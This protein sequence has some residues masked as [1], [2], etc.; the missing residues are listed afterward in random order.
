MD[1]FCLVPP[2]S[3]AATSIDL[4]VV[5]RRLKSAPVRRSND[6]ECLTIPQPRFDLPSGRTRRASAKATRTSPT[7]ERTEIVIRREV[8]SAQGIR[9]R[10]P[11]KFSEQEMQQLLERVYGDAAAVVVDPTPPTVVVYAHDVAA[12]KA[13]PPVQV[14]RRS[15]SWS[16]ETRPSTVEVSAIPLNPHYIHRPGVIAI[17]NQEK[18]VIVRA[19]SAAK[20]NEKYSH[21]RTRPNQRN[22]PL[23]ATGSLVPKRRLA[24]EIDGVPLTF[25]PKLTLNDRSA[26]LTKYFLDG[27][28][29]LVKDR[30]YNILDNID[31]RTIDKYNRTVSHVPTRSILGNRS[32]TYLYKTS[33]RPPVAT[34]DHLNINKMPLSQRPALVTTTKRN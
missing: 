11:E 26:N 23:R 21:R 12:P 3:Q 19:H 15:A 9:A 4:V 28:L 20:T 27:R 18:K 5:P 33:V 6:G 31:P 13:A 10:D 24:L 30:R 32:E 14:Y 8:K 17:R 34:F 1:L 16:Y 22:E 25:D 2:A 7:V 29:Y